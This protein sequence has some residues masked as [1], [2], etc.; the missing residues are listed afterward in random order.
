MN[1]PAAFRR[2]LQSPPVSCMG[3]YDALTAKLAEA[4]GAKALYVSG[5]AAAAVRTAEPDLGLM[6]QT[7]MAAH[8]EAICRATTLPV[9][10]DA[11][12]GYGGVLSV[13]RTVR[14]WERAGAAG[15][16][17]EDQV[18]P[19][20][21]GHVAG[22][23]VIPAEEACS[24]IRAAC[25]ARRDP[26]FF[27]IARTDAVAVTGLPDAVARCIAFAAAGADALFEDAP[28]SVEQL[29]EIAGALGHLGKPLM[30]N[31]ARTHKSPILSVAE[32]DALGY[33]LTIFPIEPLLAAIATLRTTYARLLS[34]GTSEVVAGT[35]TFAELNALLG[36]PDAMAKEQA[37]A[38]G[39]G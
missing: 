37:Y 10:S 39:G 17:L 7:E 20:R 19:K 1:R 29:R 4:A 6:S 34:E 36:M 9:V 24:K 5:F 38:A 21:C 18:F 12:T 14:L 23:A 28:E 13:E 16:H 25:A 2:L 35:A 26:D 22:K 3:V 33:P 31:C 32:L 11:D 8:L 27:I 30:F 15:L